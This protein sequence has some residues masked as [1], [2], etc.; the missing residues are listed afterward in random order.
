MFT[1]LLLLNL[2]IFGWGMQRE[3]D[4]STPQSV[5]HTGIGNI[6]LLSE[7][8]SSQKQD[9]VPEDGPARDDDSSPIAGDEA[10][11][12]SPVPGEEPTDEH[13]LME[14]G[15]PSPSGPD[16]GRVVPDLAGAEQVLGSQPDPVR[17]EPPAGQPESAR[18][19]LCGAFG[20]FERGA[21]G[22][23]VIDMLKGWGFDA[24]LRRDSLEKPVG[25]W[26]LIPPLR[27]RDAAVEK[28]A[29]LRE[30]DIT[31]VRRFV[32]GEQKNGISLGVFSSRE[33]ALKRQKE[34]SEKGHSSRIVPRT[35]TL[36]I[37]WVD[38]RANK[39]R[40]DSAVKELVARYPEMKNEEYACSRVVTPG[41][42]F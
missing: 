29:Q 26:V 17:E 4:F 21:T 15:A 8:P 31:D 25:Y 28:V 11:L 30:S 36:P 42:I 18:A 41:G 22:R 37:Y 39:A 19:V 38:Y 12:V 3:P 33:N 16:A 40:V 6:R 23:E 14:A 13:P 32:K 1:L 35:I 7:L 2:A 5:A 27:D 9:A 34:V 24:S 10:E 20:P